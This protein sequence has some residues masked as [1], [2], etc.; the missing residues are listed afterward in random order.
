MQTQE[1]LEWHLKLA[2]YREGGSVLRKRQK[3]TRVG[4]N[5]EQNLHF[6]F[7][8]HGCSVSYTE[9]IFLFLFFYLFRAI[10]GAYGGSQPRGPTGVVATGL[11]QSHS[12]ARTE[13]CLRP[14]SQLT[15]TPDPQTT[16]RGQG[17]NI[18]LMDTSRVPGLLTTE[19]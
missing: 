3:N 2:W 1:S 8:C 17:W 16:E 12:N 15:A 13:P 14:T 6:L 11:C 7:F 5:W 19:P 9:W 10:P 18:I 4:G